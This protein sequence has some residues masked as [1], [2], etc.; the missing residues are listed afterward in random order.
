MTLT[1]PHVSY[2]GNSE[3]YDEQVKPS[4]RVISNMNGHLKQLRSS[5]PDT[6]AYNNQT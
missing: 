3:R 1:D 6:P 2:N 5:S 4:N